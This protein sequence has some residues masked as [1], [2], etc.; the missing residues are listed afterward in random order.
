[1]DMSSEANNF[2]TQLLLLGLNSLVEIE[3]KRKEDVLKE[4]IASYPQ[5][6]P[7]CDVDDHMGFSICQGTY[8]IICGNCF[9]QGPMTD[10]A[11]E[12][13]VAWN[14]AYREEDI[15]FLIEGFEVD[16]ETD[17]DEK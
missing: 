14:L 5:S 9:A 6:C 3:Q 7:F 17:T 10:N 12:A 1:M 16:I 13:I 2:L 8:R 11:K 4:Q 15:E